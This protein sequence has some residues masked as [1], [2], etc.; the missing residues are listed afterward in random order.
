MHK[1]TY[2]LDGVKHTIKSQE[3]ISTADKK[4]VIPIT[5][6]QNQIACQLKQLLREWIRLADEHNID[7]FCNGGTLLGAIRD[8]GLIHYDNDLDLVVFLK[9]F[10]KI[11]NMTCGANFE[12]DYCEQGFQLHFKDKM[13]PFIDLWVE[14]PN[15]NDITKIIIAAPIKDNG[16]PTYGANFIWP[17]DNY[18]IKDVTTFVKVPFEDLV[19]NVPKHSKRYLRKM[20]GDDCLTRYVIY[21][22]TDTHSVA[23][24]VVPHHKIRMK[25]LNTLV[26]LENKPTIASTITALCGTFIANEFATSHRGKAKRHLD[27]ITRHI[28]E[29]YL[30]V[31]SPFGV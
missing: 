11:K 16:T 29:R 4:C 31:K 26:N 13:F 9:D 25:L 20:Y 10:H 2:C 3:P 22:H 1:Y 18:N 27:I 21:N 15:P 30:G 28:G 5:P 12:I 17:N 24:D 19:V 8:K 7:W 14:A 23:Y 6:E